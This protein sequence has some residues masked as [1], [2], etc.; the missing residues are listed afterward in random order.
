MYL[1]SSSGNWEKGENLLR[2]SSS[3]SYDYKK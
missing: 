2:K 3:G 1:K